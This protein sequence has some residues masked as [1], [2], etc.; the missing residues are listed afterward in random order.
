M[1]GQRKFLTKVL[2]VHPDLMHSSGEWPAEHH[3]RFAIEA[4]PLKL[5]PA[6]FAMRR[7]FAD[8][9]LVA[10]NFHRLRA[11]CLAPVK[12]NMPM[13]FQILI[14]PQ[15]C[16]HSG[17]SPSTRQTYSLRTCLLRICC[18]MSRAF[19]GFRPNMSS[20][21]VS[22]SRRWIVRRFFKLYSLARMKTTVL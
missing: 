5:C 19:L 13:N 16:T 8:P 22:L 1:R 2:Q 3:T 17:N 18:S 11:L 4:E 20:P 9:D 14:H 7:H 6:L 10:D 21:E 15:Y 12:T